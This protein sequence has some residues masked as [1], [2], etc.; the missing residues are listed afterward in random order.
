MYEQQ[1]VKSSLGLLPDKNSSQE[2]LKRSNSRTYIWKQCTEQDIDY[3]TP[4]NNGWQ[5][6]DNGLV[7]VWFTC[8]Q[9]PPS[10]SRKPS[11]KSKCG[12]EADDECDDE[13][14]ESQRRKPS[15]Q[16]AKKRRIAKDPTSS[17]KNESI[18]TLEMLSSSSK[19]DTDFVVSSDPDASDKESEYSDDF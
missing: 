8:N 7:P 9:F 4:E 19:S 5:Q 14:L 6:T 13:S 16:P 2:H 10:L 11:R 17:S 1:R 3:P 12:E 15:S 18:S